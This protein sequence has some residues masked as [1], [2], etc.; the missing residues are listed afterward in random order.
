MQLFLPMVQLRFSQDWG[1]DVLDGAGIPGSVSGAH[2]G[3]FVS[4][5]SR[6]HYG[7]QPGSERSRTYGYL[8]DQGEDYGYN[9]VATIQIDRPTGSLTVTRTQE[10]ADLDD[11]IVGRV[12]TEVHESGGV[13]YRNSA[14]SYVANRGL[15]AGITEE[16]KAREA[17]AQPE[18][19][20][21]TTWVYDTYGN[22][23]SETDPE[24]RTRYFCYDGSGA[25]G[26]PNC[27]ATQTASH[28][29]LA[30]IRDPLE[31]VSSV[32]ADPATGDLRQVTRSWSG[33]STWFDADPFGRPQTVWVQPGNHPSPTKLESR[34][35]SDEPTV[36]GTLTLGPYVERTRYA[37]ESDST[38]IRTAT[39][40]DG[41]GREI[42]RVYPTPSEFAGRVTTYDYAGRPVLETYELPCADKHCSELVPVP[43]SA[44]AVATTY[45][46][47]GRAISIQTPDGDTVADYRAATRS[48]PAGGLSG[49]TFEAVIWRDG[50]GTVTRQ[51]RDGGRVVFADECSNEQ[52]G[53]SAIDLTCSSPDETFY[54]YEPTGEVRTIYDALAS[55]DYSDPMHQLSYVYDTL[56]RITSIQDPDAGTSYTTYDL[57]GNTNSVTNAR[58]QQTFY[59]YDALDRLTLIDLPEQSATN[60]PVITYDPVTRR[61]DTEEQANGY[62][63]DHDYD[64]FGRE[65]RRI[66]EAAG[67][68]F[69]VD[70]EYDLLNRVTKVVYPSPG[71][72]VTYE[73]EGAYLKA[74]C[75]L[76]SASDCQ[77]AP[78][79]YFVSDVGYDDLGRVETITEPPGL[80]SFSYDPATYRLKKIEYDTTPDGQ[81]VDLTYG[82]DGAGNVTSVADAH[83]GAGTD[84]LDASLTVSY[85]HRSRIESRALLGSAK[86]FGY[87]ALGNLT[88]RDVASAG[89]S[90]NQLYQYPGKPHAI[91][92][93]LAP[94]GGVLKDY[95]YD[96]DG[97]TIRRGSQ[98]LAYDSQNRLTCVGS[99]PDPCGADLQH[100]YKYTIDG[101]R[102]YHVESGVGVVVYLD[103]LFEWNGLTNTATAHVYAFGRRIA[104]RVSDNA[105]LRSAWLPPAWPL[106]IDPKPFAWALAL[107]ALGAGAFGLARLG[108][109]GA[110]ASRPLSSAVSV[111][112]AV[113]LV[114]PNAWAGGPPSFGDGSS[115]WVRRWISH[116]RLGSAIAFTDATGATIQRRVFEPFGQV[117]AESPQTEAT[118]TLFTGQQLD[119]SAGLYDFKAR[120]YDAET[121]RF[122]S[123]DPLVGNI[124]DPQTHNG[125]GYVQNDPLNLTDPTGEFEG[126][127]ILILIIISIASVTAEGIAYSALS[128]GTPGAPETNA[129]QAQAPNAPDTS[130]TNPP[131]S[132]A[133]RIAKVLAAGA[134]RVAADRGEDQARTRESQREANVFVPPILPFRTPNPWVFIGGN[135]VFLGIWVYSVWGPTVLE[136]S[137]LGEEGVWRVDPD[138]GEITRVDPDEGRKAETLQRK[139]LP[140]QVPVGPP[141]QDPIG[142]EP[143]PKNTW[144]RIKRF[145][146]DSIELWE[147]W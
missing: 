53:A 12:A 77:T 48:Q 63:V 7:G 88:K 147:S 115:T 129:T 93:L 123:V 146:K 117:V 90:A 128:N 64:D 137:E 130:S 86:Y 124:A 108:F 50:R 69:V 135:L 24:E 118:A 56:G 99:G 75:G 8:D 87:D 4:Q 21:I 82:Y 45:D 132:T 100:H 28:T 13:Q 94:G 122:L 3:R 17:G 25:S 113:T 143:P 18:E 41:L 42:R 6:S 139:P 14:L 35:Y 61:R 72:D 59:Q 120:W 47:L 140:Q 51:L 76:G 85:D 19:S 68:T 30:S 57:V 89:A 1:W 23:L 142:E 141:G 37:S 15:I 84:G 40:F 38:G 11:W 27:P 98:H 46:A 83:D 136:Q 96:A 22:V 110:V 125:Y 9:F 144:E 131:N 67:L 145:I 126:I 104:S 34:S 44:A 73:Y 78:D 62:S 102:Y 52:P 133:R 97:N 20:A 49:S 121:G 60:D 26:V 114:A 71:T 105:S 70:F 55:L 109:Y 101:S 79:D 112:L 127:S 92:A 103:D 95:A 106:P 134:A 33:E 5:S 74:V 116:D 32:V 58:G 16:V 65:K 54:T 138:T 2:V 39:Y 80:R 107:L 36:F 91:S 111:G 66:F 43:P 119:G 10:P 81:V 31:G 29:L